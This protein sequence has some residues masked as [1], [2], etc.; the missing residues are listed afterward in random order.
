MKA[1]RVAILLLLTLALTMSGAA[2][3][4]DAPPSSIVAIDLESDTPP[5]YADEDAMRGVTWDMTIA[6][7]AAA[8]SVKAGKRTLVVIKDGM[9]HSVAVKKLTYTFDAQGRLLSRK[10]DLKSN[11][12][13]DSSFYSIFMRYGVPFQMKNRNGTW[14][15][16]DMQIVVK[17]GTTSSITFT[18]KE[19]ADTNDGQ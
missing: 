18:H 6:E 14:E 4:E 2:M 19:G 13:Y 10:F 17:Y 9:L 3:A 8:E 5:L 7:V 1:T 12:D 11:K 15:L 16:R